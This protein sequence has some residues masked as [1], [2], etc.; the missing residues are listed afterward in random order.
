MQLTER[1]EAS[2]SRTPFYHIT[3]HLWRARRKFS[4]LHRYS[5]SDGDGKIR[6]TSTGVDIEPVGSRPSDRHTLADVRQISRP[7]S[8]ARR[9]NVDG[10]AHGVTGVAI[11]W[12]A[13][14]LA[15]VELTVHVAA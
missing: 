5:R 9:S 6:D 14:P 1:F 7:P 10:V 2:N 8:R 3:R 13:E 12:Q 4:F 11:A 15:S